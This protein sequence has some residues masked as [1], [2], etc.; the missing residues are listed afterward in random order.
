MAPEKVAVYN[1][2]GK[3]YKKVVLI[4]LSLY[5]LANTASSSERLSPINFKK[6]F[7]QAYILM[8]LTF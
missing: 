2:D 3:K 5:T 7:S 4:T 8:I 6:I 1:R